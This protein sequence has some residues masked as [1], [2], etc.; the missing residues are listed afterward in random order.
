MT[1]PY[2]RV[3][4]ALT[5]RLRKELGDKLHSSVLY[6]SVA[7]KEA[8]ED[9]DIDL[10]LVVSDSKLCERI[11]DISYDVDLENGILTAVFCVTPEELGRYVEHGSPFIDN[12]AE[13]GITLYD[14]GTFTA[15][16][17]RLLEAGR[18]VAAGS[19]ASSGK[20]VLGVWD[21]NEKIAGERLGN[22]C[23]PRSHRISS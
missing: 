10:L 14:D 17:G 1:M 15:I 20:D 8:R 2:E 9:S 11:S 21:G 4:K 5:R 16:R 7:R 3:A 23:S 12:V 19:Q 22:A 6:G 13:E 18:G